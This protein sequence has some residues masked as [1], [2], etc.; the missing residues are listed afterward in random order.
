M[1]LLEYYFRDNNTN[2]GGQPVKIGPGHKPRLYCEEHRTPNYVPKS[3]NIP[4]GLIQSPHRTAK[5][6]KNKCRQP[7][8]RDGAAIN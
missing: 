6:G 2:K 3:R 1:C 7:R 5:V 8:I 4:V